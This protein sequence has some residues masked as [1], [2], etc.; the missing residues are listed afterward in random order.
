MNLENFTD[1][2]NSLK[3]FMDFIGDLP[4][5][6]HFYNNLNANLRQLRDKNHMLQQRQHD[7]REQVEDEEFQTGMR[8]RREVDNWLTC[9]G[10]KGTEVQ[11][12]LEAATPTNSIWK[13]LYVAWLGNLAERMIEEVDELYSSGVFPEVLLRV[14]ERY[15]LPETPMEGAAA[16]ENTDRILGWLRN[17]VSRI[18]VHGI[19]GI[20]KTAVVTHIFNRLSKNDDV[21][22][23]MI[24][25]GDDYGEY[26]LQDEIAKEVGIELREEDEP[27]RAAFLYRALKQRNFVLILDGLKKHVSEY[28]IGIP[29]DAAKGKM[30][31]TSR[32]RDVCRK[33]GCQN[34]MIAID[35]LPDDEALKLFK[36]TGVFVVQP[37][38]A[39]ESVMKKIVELCRGVPEKIIEMGVHLRGVEDDS[40]WLETL[41]EM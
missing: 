36:R 41:K 13:F 25:V 34:N 12:F 16:K 31:I 8:R 39:M 21:R 22:V 26:R 38:S 6:I 40:V 4:R 9:A 19:R 29:L 35:P 30:I 28:N 15:D 7:L 11:R 23:Y 1:G 2:I 5:W 20:G 37:D 17:G 32:S 14:R 18:G 3:G 33:T 10:T 27:K 24:V